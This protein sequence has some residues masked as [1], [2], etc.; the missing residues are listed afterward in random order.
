MNAARQEEQRVQHTVDGVIG[1]EDH[2]ADGS[3]DAFDAQVEAD[4]VDGHE[5][6]DVRGTGECL[7]V[8]V[9]PRGAEPSHVGAT[10]DRRHKVLGYD[11]QYHQPAPREQ[12]QRC[13]VP[14]GREGEDQK[15]AKNVV[16]ASTEW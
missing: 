12:V 14:H 3:A 15:D 2:F 8:R 1:L 13:I 9:I 7:E 4:Q 11:G 10:A 5:E 16:R 6:D